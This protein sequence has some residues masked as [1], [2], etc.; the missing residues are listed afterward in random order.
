LRRKNAVYADEPRDDRGNARPMLSSDPEKPLCQEGRGGYY[1]RPLKIEV[2]AALRMILDE[3]LIFGG[4][5][6]RDQ[7][8][9]KDSRMIEAA[10]VDGFISRLG[11]ASS[12]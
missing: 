9:E 5:R 6:V 10:F 7:Q 4:E 3:A 11:I 1:S 12:I 8:G 2:W